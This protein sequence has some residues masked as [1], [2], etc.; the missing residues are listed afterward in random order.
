MI[1]LYVIQ[2]QYRWI[3]KKS[4]K[5]NEIFDFGNLGQGI[6]LEVEHNMDGQSLYNLGCIY[7]NRRDY[8]NA[9][10]MYQLA[11]DKGNVDATCSLAQIYHFGHGVHKDREKAKELYEKAVSGGN[12]FG[13]MGLIALDK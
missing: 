3:F 13:I 1:G 2:Y 9:I 5:L 10:N 6:I 8:Q 12:S 7:E 11:S 4:E